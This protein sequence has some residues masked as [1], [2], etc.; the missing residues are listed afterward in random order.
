MPAGRRL[1]FPAD[2]EVR[3][4]AGLKAGAGFDYFENYRSRPTDKIGPL[5]GEVTIRL[6]GSRTVRVKAVDTGGRPVPGV[7]LAPG[8]F[9]SRRSS[10]LPTLKYWRACA[11]TDELG[12][13]TFNWLPANV[14]NGVPIVVLLGEYSCPS[15]PTF[16]GGVNETV[17][18]ARL[19]RNARIGGVVRHADGRPAA[20]I[21]IPAEDEGRPI[22]IAAGT[23]ESR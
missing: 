6:D 10:M 23:P 4:V 9:G 8:S 7:E 1:H 21:L 5:P 19:L 18:E 3:W 11:R 12:M 22:S 2:A 20:G 15:S 13:A 14:E 16:S 17:L